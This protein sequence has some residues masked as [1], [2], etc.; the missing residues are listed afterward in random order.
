MQTQQKSTAQSATRPTAVCR[1]AATNEATRCDAKDVIQKFY[2]AY[3]SPAL[4]CSHI[5]YSGLQIV[6]LS[7]HVCLHSRYNSGDVEAVMALMAEDV[8]YHD[9]ALYQ[10]PFRGKDA[11][12]AYFQMVTA[13]VPGDLKFT[14]EHITSGDPHAVGVRW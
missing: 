11:V 7:G 14:L 6:K 9:L 13:T 5:L 10:E 8:A 2:T 12:R 4:A 3:V 1:A